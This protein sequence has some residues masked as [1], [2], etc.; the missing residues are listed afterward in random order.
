MTDGTRELREAK[1]PSRQDLVETAMGFIR[2]K[3]LCAAVRLGIADALARGPMTLDE[4]AAA[5]KTNP[6][7]LRRFMRG[8]AC[9]GVVEEIAPSRYGLTTSGDP[10]RRHAQHSVWASMIFWADLL[11]DAWTYLPECIRAG[12]RSGADAARAREGAVSRWTREPDAKAIFHAVFAEPNAEDFAPLVAAWDFSSARVVADLGGGGGLLAAILS[13]HPALRGMLVERQT[14]LDG[15]AKKLESAGLATRCELVA[16]D[17][18]ESVPAGADVYLMRCVLHGYDDE[19]ALAILRNLRRAMSAASRLLLIEVVLPDRIDG[20]DPEL[21]RLILSDLNML[22]VT[23]GR[24]RSED[25]WTAL[26]T[27]SSLD[28]RRRI[29]VGGDSTSI[30]EV[31]RRG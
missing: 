9:I 29:R 26:L 2:G 22:A 10:L 13:A 7:A 23:G 27:S 12:D 19:S 4:L 6:A 11:A 28:L 5:T 3:V 20:P 8:L 16:G 18:L 31:A 15:A 14:A 21:E 24:E 25:E 30:L 1:G 17:L